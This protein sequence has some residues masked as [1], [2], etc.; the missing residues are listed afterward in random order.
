MANECT[1]PGTSRRLD[2]THQLWHEA[3]NGY[4]DADL[5]CL[6]VNSLLT[7]A[8]SVTWILQR[9]LSH[10][11][12]FAAWYPPWQGQMKADPVMRW[13]VEARNMVEKQGDLDLR[14]T[15][16]VS[17]VASWLPA[18]ITEFEAPPLLSAAQIAAMVDTSDIPD[19]VRKHGYL[20]VER[21]WVTRSLPD[22]ELL[23]GIAHCVGCI[24]A[25]VQDAHNHYCNQEAGNDSV[26]A[27]PPARR[28][29]AMVANRE[30]R[31][32]ALHLVT[33]EIIEIESVTP[34]MSTAM[35]ANVE[36][37][38]GRFWEASP[39][40]PGRA[41]DQAQ[42]YHEWGKTFLK[43]DGNHAPFVWLF[44]EGKPVLMGQMFPEDQQDKML[45]M[46]RIAGEVERLSADAIIVSTEA[47]MALA[48]PD[49]DDRRRLR[50][51]ERDD[52]MEAFV[53]EAVQRGGLSVNLTT[54]FVRE[55]E[56]IVFAQTQTDFERPALSFEPI[57]RVW[58]T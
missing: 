54:M 18:P 49:N 33:G 57:L 14:S 29:P 34:D 46:E 52:R 10:E 20:L 12:D 42:V 27:H 39:K 22:Q 53:T 45:M 41:I 1:I 32:A 21:Q 8:R 51:G 31:S 13:L 9:E 56:G 44:K 15:A 36:E 24:D 23:E 30:S 26:A 40:P 2:Q 5:F 17:V 19:D 37:R 43:R 35:D 6:R 25:L 48:V 28:L 7:A 55:S 47:W 3:L 11:A 16:R 58:R 4:P 38:Y 50:A